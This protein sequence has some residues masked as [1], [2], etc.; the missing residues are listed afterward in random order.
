[1]SRFELPHWRRLFR[2]PTPDPRDAAAEVDSEL[3]F[4]LQ[5]RVDELIAL[6]MTEADARAEA[7]RRFGNLG[8]TR[9]DLTRDGESR[10]R[11][12]RTVA[13]LEDLVQDL[14]LALRGMRRRPALA[15]VAILTLALG[16]GLTTTVFAVVNRL[17]LHAL[18][19]PGADRFASVVLAS[20]E[21]AMRI[22][23]TLRMLGAWRAHAPGSEWIEAHNREELLLE[24][25][26]AAELVQTR[27]VTPGLL[28]ALGARV[29]AGRGI[30]PADTAA[31]APFV[32]LLSWGAWQRRYGGSADIIG[33]TVRL[34]GKVAA[35]IGVLERGF[36]LSPLDAS[37]R[38][39]FWLPR[40]HADGRSRIDSTLERAGRDVPDR[41]RGGRST[42][43]FERLFATDHRHQ[44][45]RHP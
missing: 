18:P 36:D 39:E 21:T 15:A 23:P 4:H 3:E 40:A 6:G 8:R 35:V 41:P 13:W 45:R 5:M 33:H 16:L 14:R 20:D 30:E 27:S 28:P 42:C 22:S 25:G 34:D 26:E 10:A 38:A 43:R 17:V 7:L 44:G 19:Y 24:S 1:V 9:G 32:V 2:L 11:R 12:H 37:A 31:G 29:I